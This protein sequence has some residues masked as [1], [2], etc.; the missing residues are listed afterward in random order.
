MPRHAGPVVG[1]KEYD[2]VV[3][4]PVLFQLVKD[5]LNVLIHHRNAV[6]EPRNCLS[7]EWSVRIVR[8][9]RDGSRIADLLFRKT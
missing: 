9:Q 4:D 5:A 8:W 3:G 6:V 7:D 1:V 2:R